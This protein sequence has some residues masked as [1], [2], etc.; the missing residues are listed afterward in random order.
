MQYV[1]QGSA[2]DVSLSAAGGAASNLQIQMVDVESIHD[3]L[4]SQSRRFVWSG[5]A[6]QAQLSSGQQPGQLS[7]VAGE[8]LQVDFKSPTESLDFA[9]Q[10]SAGSFAFQVSGFDRGYTGSWGIALGADS[11][12]RFTDSIEF[13]GSSATFHAGEI[14]VA[15]ACRQ[16]MPLCK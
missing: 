14:E 11:H 2:T 13:H 9:R 7:L 16:T 8:N 1:F 10:S 15:E 5:D 12:L 3:A 4:T 6:Q